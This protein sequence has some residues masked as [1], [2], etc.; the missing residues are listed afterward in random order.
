M[1]DSTPCGAVG[2]ACCLAGAHAGGTVP[3]MGIHWQELILILLLVLV[4]FGPR[5]LP[6][7]GRSLG[8]GFREFKD[9]VSGNGSASVHAEPSAERVAVEVEPVPAGESGNGSR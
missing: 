9:S 2:R 7:I 4:L 3:S 1:A 8:S 6:E 5:R